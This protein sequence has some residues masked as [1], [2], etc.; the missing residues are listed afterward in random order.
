MSFLPE[1]L[2][3]R[4]GEESD[5]GS[6]RG[7]RPSRTE[8]R[9]R[10]RQGGRT[11]LLPPFCAYIYGYLNCV[12]SGRQLQREAGRNGAPMWLPGRLVLGRN[13]MEAIA[14]CAAIAI[15]ARLGTGSTSRQSVQ[16][17]RYFGAPL[18][19]ALSPFS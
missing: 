19:M 14:F 13:P 6:R 17:R 1:R 12:Q 10:R 7:P 5:R 4:V 3:D 15:A 11:A 8:R 16:S 18:S 2:N 9:W